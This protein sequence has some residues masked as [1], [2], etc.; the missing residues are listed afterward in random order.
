MIPRIPVSWGELADRITILE[1]KGERL[2]TES[3]RGNVRRELYELWLVAGTAIID[4][5]DHL[6]SLRQINRRLWDLE[7]IVR[8]KE[9]QQQ[10]DNTFIEAARAIYRNNDERARIKREI[11]A[12]LQSAIIEEKEH[13]YV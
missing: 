8:G 5:A 3:A 10:F 2:T 13:A 9:A 7:N 4:I 11:N 12:I 6:D 1:I